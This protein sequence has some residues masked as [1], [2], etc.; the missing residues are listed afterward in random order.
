MLHYWYYKSTT[1]TNWLSIFQIYILK[2]FKTTRVWGKPVTNN[3]PI[4]TP[5]TFPASKK[6]TEKAREIE[7]ISDDIY[8]RVK[9]QSEKKITS[10]TTRGRYCPDM[11]S[12]SSKP[13]LR[14]GLAK[15]TA[16]VLFS[17]RDQRVKNKDVFVIKVQ[18]TWWFIL[19]HFTMVSRQQSTNC[20][21]NVN[22]TGSAWSSL[23][24]N[25]PIYGYN[26]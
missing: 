13:P 21:S 8:C 23:M 25:Y 14:W 15:E 20:M 22:L 17:T 9:G 6:N 10:V 7:M 3:S 11:I 16:H 18:L 26:F 5:R 24:F 19:L 12:I 2:K 1:F 4:G